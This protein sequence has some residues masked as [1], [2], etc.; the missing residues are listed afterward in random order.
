[1]ENVLRLT[2][3][4][5]KGTKWMGS[6]CGEGVDRVQRENS[7]RIIKNFSFLGCFS[8]GC[9]M[10]LMVEKRNSLCEF[11]AQMDNFVVGQA[12]NN[13]HKL[14]RAFVQHKRKHTEISNKIFIGTRS[15]F[16]L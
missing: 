11:I 13:Q 12:V 2:F 8:G 16:S 15:N 10:R 4:W 6:S 1:M 9:L 5:R 7:T 14:Q 3:D